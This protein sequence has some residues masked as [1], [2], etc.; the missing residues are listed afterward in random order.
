[1]LQMFPQDFVVDDHPGPSRPAQHAG[2]AAGNQR[3]PGHRF[4][5]GTHCLVGAV[6]QAHLLAEETVFEALAG[7]YA[8]VLPEN[9]QEGIARRRH[10]RALDANW[11]S[12]TATRCTWLRRFTVCGDH[13]T[14]DLAQA[15]CIS[16]DDAELI[17]LEFG[18]AVAGALP[19]ERLVELPPRE[20]RER[21][22][23]PRRFL[24]QI[25]EAR[26]EELFRFVR[27][28]L[29]RVGMDRS[30]MGGVFL[31]G[32]GASCPGCAMS[33]SAS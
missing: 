1:M 11:S 24:N 7:C 21:R 4:A 5:A 3:S 15:L 12:I 9:R 13:F 8:A 25:L 33:R 27:T 32:G 29:A 2:V 26:A 28:E 30:L 17:K 18:G 22:D 23:A 10:R 20:N 19:G 14:R 16:Y 31:T 6:N